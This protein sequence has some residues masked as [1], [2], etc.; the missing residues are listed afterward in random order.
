MVLLA[1]KTVGELVVDLR[2]TP[3]SVVAPAGQARGRRRPARAAGRRHG[4]GR[5]GR[6]ARARGRGVVGAFLTRGSPRRQQRPRPAATWRSTTPEEWKSP[7]RRDCSWACTT[8]NAHRGRSRRDGRPRLGVLQPTAR[9]PRTADATRPAA[10]RRGSCSSRTPG[11]ARR[12]RWSGPTAR[13]GR[14]A[15]T[16]SA[17]ATRPTRTGLRTASA[18]VFA[19]SDGERDDLWVADVD[20][21]HARM[22]LDCGGRCRWLDDPD[23]SPDGKR[24]VYSR[25]IERADGW[26]I[27]TLETVDVAT[28]KVRVVLGPWKRYFTAGARFSPDGRQVVFEKVHKIGRGPDADIDAVT[29]SVVRLDK[30]RRTRSA[31]SRTRDCSPR[32]P[33]G[34]RTGSASST[35]PWPQPDAE[36]PDLFWIRPVGRRAD[37]AHPRGRRRRASRPSRPGC[38]TAPGCC[39]AGCLEAGPAARSC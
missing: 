9:Q 21:E 39:S 28:G 8:R 20:G 10:S 34:A 38:P 25:T 32:R 22:L 29:L 30:P 15:A 33:T 13:T 12:W 27:G 35:P 2:T 37:A 24:I 6:P 1:G 11:P 23:W 14:A 4:P 7:A 26:G 17:R 31:R 5:A 16:T 36:A 18:V 19:M 3:A